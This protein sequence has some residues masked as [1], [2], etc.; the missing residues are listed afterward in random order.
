[1]D[2]TMGLVMCALAAAA[3]APSSEGVESAS[4]ELRLGHVQVGVCGNDARSTY[5]QTSWQDA[6]PIHGVAGDHAIVFAVQPTAGPSRAQGVHIVRRA[7]GQHLGDLPAPPLGWGTPLS[8]FVT[9]FERV[10]ALGSRGEFLLTDVV[11]RP[12]DALTTPTPQRLYRYSY[13]YSPA[14]GFHSTLLST[15]IVPP[16]TVA[17]GAGLPNGFGYIGSVVGLP[18]GGVVLTDTFTGALWYAPSAAGPFVLTLIDERFSPSLVGSITGVQRAPGGGYRPYTQVLPSPPGTTLGF[19]PGIE[20]ITYADVTD[21]ICVAPTAR[22]GLFCVPR[23]AIE[24]TATP[25]VAKVA[26]IR[27]VIA[28]TP[29]LTDLTDGLT[30]DRYHPSSPWLYW[31]RA[32]S[33]TTPYDGSGFNTLRRVNLHTG[34]YE[35]VAKSNACFDWTYEIAPLPPVIA[36]SP[37]TTIISSVGQGPN[38]GDINVSLGG[39]SQFVGPTILPITLTTSW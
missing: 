4:E 25:P 13:S 20:S 22:G 37:F 32:P 2:R 35:V 7:D 31:H 24:D 1:M 38:N 12:I 21:E 26:S 14:T 10:G 34:A 11:A 5:L 15:T 8:P 30:F 3:C 23:S 19:G 17:P 29:G 33:D 39:V 28:P 27:A 9:R 36:G 16:N 18:N 6:F